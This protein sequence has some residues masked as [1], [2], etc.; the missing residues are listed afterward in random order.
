MRTLIRCASKHAK[1]GRYSVGF[2]DSWRRLF[3]QQIAGLVAPVKSENICVASKETGDGTRCQWVP[4]TLGWGVSSFSNVCTHTEVCLW[5]PNEMSLAA[6]FGWSVSWSAV[7]GDVRDIERCAKDKY[8]LFGSRL[9]QWVF[10]LWT[11]FHVYRFVRRLVFVC[12]CVVFF[13]VFFCGDSPQIR[14]RKR[15]PCNKLF[16]HNPHLTRAPK[17]SSQRHTG[18]TGQRHSVCARPASKFGIPHETSWL[19]DLIFKRVV[20]RRAV[21][22]TLNVITISLYV[23]PYV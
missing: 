5:G 18:N 14:D 12:V 7:C 8:S 11:E 1:S 22:H 2:S 23:R 6:H 10:I 9:K 13:F 21:Y 3:R 16:S 17:D 19:G 20:A 4:M 15:H